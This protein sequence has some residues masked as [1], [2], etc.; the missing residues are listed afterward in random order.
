MAPLLRALIAQLG[1][2]ELHHRVDEIVPMFEGAIDVHATIHLHADAFTD[3]IEYMD[4]HI[5]MYS[6]M[7][8]GDEGLWV[9]VDLIKYIFREDKN[10]RFRLSRFLKSLT[11]KDYRNEEEDLLLDLQMGNIGTSFMSWDMVLVLLLQEGVAKES[12][13]GK[14][15]GKAKE[16]EQVQEAHAEE[17][18]V[19]EQW[20]ASMALMALQENVPEEVPDLL[21][22]G[23]E[24]LEEVPDLVVMS[25][26]PIIIDGKEFLFLDD[27]A[28]TLGFR[29]DE[30]LSIIAMNAG[31]EDKWKMK[32]SF[33]D[34]N[35]TKALAY[36]IN[37]SSLEDVVAKALVEIKQDAQFYERLPD[38]AFEPHIP[39]IAGDAQGQGSINLTNEK[40]VSSDDATEVCPYFLVVKQMIFSCII[41][42]FLTSILTC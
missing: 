4:Q 19:T 3:V 23:D 20:E 42:R 35:L 13:K 5:S 21:L 38:S 7:F 2:L 37:S 9:P 40:L 34:D 1:K 10:F 6:I 30:A 22:E 28:K 26:H 39:L 16:M 36:D 8:E 41:S 33:E 11:E 14:E 12:G 32:I 27:I 29:E 17:E 15:R 31:G 25:L 24:V 18:N